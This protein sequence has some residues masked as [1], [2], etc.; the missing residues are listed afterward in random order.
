MERRGR[1]AWLGIVL[2]SLVLG[3]LTVSPRVEIMGDLDPV[4]NPKLFVTTRPAWERSTADE[5]WVRRVPMLLEEAGLTV[6]DSARDADLVLIGW[7]GPAGT[8]A[9]CGEIRNY[10]LK[11]VQQGF[12]RISI[13]GR[14]CERTIVHQSVA[15]LVRLLQQE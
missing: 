9:R 10:E 13:S 3:C 7:F 14:N 2:A 1:R 8:P 5:R 6:V 15:E 4:E 11:I 12:T